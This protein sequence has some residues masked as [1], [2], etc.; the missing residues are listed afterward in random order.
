MPVP[1]PGLKPHR[2]LVKSV[3]HVFSSGKESEGKEEVGPSQPT[4][5]K[6]SKAGPS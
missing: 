1:V 6:E 5:V 2:R 4:L 3:V